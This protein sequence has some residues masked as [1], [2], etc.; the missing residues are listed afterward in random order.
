MGPKEK[1]ERS[2]GEHLQLKAHRCATPKC[3]L[4]R[5]P[6]KPGTHGPSNKRPRALSEFG[7][8]LKEKQKFKVSYGL[9]ERNLRVLFEEARQARG[10]TAQKI[11]ELLER[12]LDNALFRAG[13][14]LSRGMGRQMLVHGHITVN[15]TIVRSPGFL[16]DAGDVIAVKEAS[17]SRAAF[18][19]LRDPQWRYE[20]PAWISLDREKLEAKILSIP[21]DIEPPFEVKLLVEAFSK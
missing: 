13:V 17:K 11:L 15:G 4:V 18:K 6:Y 3:A 16:V 2:L 5:K 7:V 21:R 1:K 12:R 8:Q 20:V 19:H 14:A 9:D 10:S